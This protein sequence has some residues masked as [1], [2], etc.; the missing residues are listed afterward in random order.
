VKRSNP[1]TTTTKPHALKDPHIQERTEEA[2]MRR[3]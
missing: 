1:T 3:G 2:P